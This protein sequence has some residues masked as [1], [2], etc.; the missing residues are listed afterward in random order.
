MKSSAYL[1][2][3][4]ELYVAGAAW[5]PVIISTEKLG[6]QLGLSQQAVSKQLIHLEKEGLVVRSRAGRR[7]TTILTKE[8]VDVVLSLYHRL[9]TGVDRRSAI[10]FRGRVF[11]GLGEGAYYISLSGYRRQFRRL[12]GFDPFPGTLNLTLDNSQLEMRK[13]LKFRT[14]LEVKGFKDSMRT[15]GPVKCFEAKVEGKQD[16]AVLLIER[17]HHGESVIEVISPV[18]L[19]KMFALNDGDEVSVTLFP[20]D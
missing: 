4:L 11:T 7:T 1:Q 12:L 20:R 8:G 13:M 9:K 18:N 14:G 17:T 6:G 5:A 10:A 15:Y 3:L 19:R 16:A 2:T